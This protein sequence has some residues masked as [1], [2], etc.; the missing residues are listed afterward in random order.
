MID[1]QAP[2]AMRS[3]KKYL[4]EVGTIA[5]LNY[6]NVPGATILEEFPGLRVNEVYLI[7]LDDAEDE[8]FD[9]FMRK[10]NLN[11]PTFNPWLTDEV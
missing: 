4:G 2:V 8:A 6:N 10:L 1:P 9:R 11:D 7:P 5:A 3:L